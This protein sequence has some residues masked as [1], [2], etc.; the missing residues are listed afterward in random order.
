MSV[1]KEPARELAASIQA[2]AVLDEAHL[3]HIH[4]AFGTILRGD[5]GPRIGGHARIKTLL[6]ILGPSLIVMVGDNDAGTFGTYTQAGRNYGTTLLWTLMR[7][8]P[9]LYV[10]QEMVLRLGAVS[11]VGHARLI[12]E[13][14]GKLWGA[15]SVI[16]LFLLNALTIR[17]RVHW[18]HFGA[19]LS[20]TAEEPRPS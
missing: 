10:N 2:S 6:A 5:H 18:D 11:G 20:R 13:R 4:G 16:D 1:M 8:I 9:V 12:L 19:R 14:F 15:F 17:H 3:G 7:L